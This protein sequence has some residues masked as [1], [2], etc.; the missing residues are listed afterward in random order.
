[1]LKKSLSSDSWV[2]P[3][4]T[5]NKENRLTTVPQSQSGRN[6][7]LTS[8]M[9]C[10]ESVWLLTGGLILL[11][12]S[13]WSLVR[14]IPY[15]YLIDIKVD[16]PYFAIPAS[17]LCFPCFW[18]SMS[19]HNKRKKYE[20]LHLL[21][22]LL[23]ISMALLIAGTSLSFI[24]LS[25][26]SLN[27]TASTM[28]T[29]LNAQDLNISLQITFLE[30]ETNVHYA[31]GWEKMQSQLRCCGI[32]SYVDWGNLKRP[33]PDSCCKNPSCTERS[34][35]QRGCLD[36]LSRDLTWHQNVLNSQCYMVLVVQV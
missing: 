18:I 13:I 19:I 16:V 12:V 7:T 24:Y 9:L 28:I 35:N 4:L 10:F 14:K 17:F 8:F 23:V 25:R 30:S 34:V 3:W 11:G 29:T 15:S 1:M 26:I 27:S 33:L 32:S 36:C 5:K 6:V 20:F 21:I 22:L 31:T 2:F